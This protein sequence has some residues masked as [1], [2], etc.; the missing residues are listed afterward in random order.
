MRIAVLSDI[1]GN[2]HALDAVLADLRM[3]APDMVVDLG[4]SLSGPLRPAETADRLAA[5]DPVAIRGNHE[6][7]M[8]TLGIDEMNA[9]DSRTWPRLASRHRERLRALP[10][11]RTVAD[12]AVLLCH[13]SPD[14]DLC[15]L[16]EEI[17]ADGAVVPAAPAT[18]AARLGTA[19]GCHAVVL[20]GHTHLPRQLRLPDGGLVVNPGSVGLP[21]YRDDRPLPHVVETG[22]PHARYALVELDGNG[23]WSARFRTIAYDWQRSAGEARAAGRPDWAHALAT[24]RAPAA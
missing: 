1:H 21:A 3:Q 7:Q 23:G 16:M 8:L 4:D 24:G 20:C 9:S 18:V 14:D 10:A 2:L 22:S 15:Y 17:T 19:A 5:L 11:T 6:R 12:G 13:G